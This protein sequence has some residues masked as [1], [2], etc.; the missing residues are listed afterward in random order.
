MT[1][2]DLAVFLLVLS[3]L[4]AIGIGLWYR[5]LGATSLATA[6]FF[7]LIW[8]AAIY[9]V[10]TDW[11]GAGDSADCWPRCTTLQSAI[12]AVLFMAPVIAI[13]LL[14]GAFARAAISHGQPKN[15]SRGR[16]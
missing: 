15:R 12:S 13:A 8:I 5:R 2:N 10:S 16:R 11:H 1:W 6:A 4:L 9:A 7:G 14:F 3:A